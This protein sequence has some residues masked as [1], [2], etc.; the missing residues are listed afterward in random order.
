MIL[1]ALSFSFQDM[2]LFGF[3]F[4]EKNAKKKTKNVALFEIFYV[5]YPQNII[6]LD[7]GS[8]SVELQLS[9]MTIFGNYSCEHL[10]DIPLG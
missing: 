9:F 1:V 5:I 3:V 2:V 6:Q 7:S 10:S 8:Y 4:M